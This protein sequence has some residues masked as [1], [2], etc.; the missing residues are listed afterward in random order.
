MNDLSS[1]AGIVGLVGCGLAALTLLAT[2]FGLALAP[3]EPGT[4][5]EPGL[6]RSA[7][8]MFVNGIGAAPA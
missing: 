4:G 6:L 1:T 2:L 5:V 8:A 3:H 7:V